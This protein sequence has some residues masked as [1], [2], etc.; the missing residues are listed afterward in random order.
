MPTRERDVEL[1]GQ[2]P[3]ALK[4]A[5]RGLRSRKTEFEQI[6]GFLTLTNLDTRSAHRAVVLAPVAKL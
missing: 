4:L 5:M 3:I 2:G 1:I 6:V